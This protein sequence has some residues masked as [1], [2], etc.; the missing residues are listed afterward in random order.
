M[1][2]DVQRWRSWSGDAA[3]WSHL[4]LADS[5]TFLVT[6]FAG[7]RRSGM[8]QIRRPTWFVVRMCCAAAAGAFA[9][10]AAGARVAV[11]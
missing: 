9:G 7:V 8:T 6:C 1:W 4:E 10:A 5:A 11:V 2:R 3:D